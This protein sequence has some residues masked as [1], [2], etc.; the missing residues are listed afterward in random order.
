[1]KKIR[2]LVIVLLA[3]GASLFWAMTSERTVNVWGKDG[4]SYELVIPA[5]VTVHESKDEDNRSHVQSTGPFEDVVTE[6]TLKQFGWKPFAHVKVTARTLPSGDTFLYDEVVFTEETIPFTARFTPPKDV[7]AWEQWAEGRVNES[8]HDVFGVDATDVAAG[9]ATSDHGSFVV[10]QSFHSVEKTYE[11]EETKT[12]STI[13]VLRSERAP[14]LVPN[15][16]IERRFDAPPWERMDGWILLSN[17]ALFSSKE[18]MDD[19][20]A[21]AEEETYKRLNWLTADGAYTKLAHSIE[22]SHPNGYGRVLGRMQDDEALRLYESTRERWYENLVAHSW[23]TLIQYQTD[24]LA[25]GEANGSRW[26]TEFTSTWLKNAYGVTAPYVDTRYNEYI[27]FFLD[28]VSEQFG[29]KVAGGTNR[30]QEVEQYARFLLDRIEAGDVL[31][32]PNGYLLIDYF[33][34]D[35]PAPLITHASLNHELGGLKILLT[36]YERTKEAAFL[37]AAEQIMTGIEEAGADQG[38][39][40]RPNGDL[41]YQMRPDGTMSSDD[42]PQ[43]TL[44]DLLEANELLEQIGKPR[45]VSFDDMIDAKVRFLQE[46]GVAFIP[47]VS[48]LLKRRDG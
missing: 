33:K 45:N 18:A 16:S 40:I 14:T 10:S 2:L 29:W 36:A 15:S 20:V 6:W 38:G 42:Y 32:T 17:E 39:W 23:V 41:W 47:K 28:D 19:Y 35:A 44:L 43:L 8:H 13:R 1:M 22:P 3:I 11:D 37:H 5:Y 25:S 31:R 9:Y 34:E 21:F 26:P 27:A 12:N 24:K 7:W 46:E 30:S 48:E 4:F